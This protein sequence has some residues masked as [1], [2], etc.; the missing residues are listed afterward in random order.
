M[1]KTYR[2][3]TCV[4]SGKPV[5]FETMRMAFPGHKGTYLFAFLLSSVLQIQHDSKQGYWILCH[6]VSS[7]QRWPKGA[8]SR[9]CPLYIYRGPAWQSSFAH[10][11]KSHIRTTEEIWA[12]FPA[13]LSPF[14][15]QCLNVYGQAAQF[16]CHFHSSAGTHEEVP[17]V[18]ICLPSNSGKWYADGAII[19]SLILFIRGISQRILHFKQFIRHH[20]FACRASRGGGKWRNRQQIV[21]FEVRALLN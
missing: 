2:K 8:V 10:S 9:G 21:H 6:M 15:E 17:R 11:H 1:E 4:D 16:E 14:P 13:C 5:G 19:T 20:L 7:H 12:F 18:T 3:K